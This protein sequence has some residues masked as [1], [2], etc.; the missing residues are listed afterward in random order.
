MKRP[1]I[2][3]RWAGKK[4]PED[5]SGT[6]TIHNDVYAYIGD[7]DSFEAHSLQEFI[8]NIAEFY[9]KQGILDTHNRIQYNLQKIK[10]EAYG[11]W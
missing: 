3:L 7:F 6:C 9:Y 11:T 10:E 1:Q 5:A 4:D 2:N 8:Q